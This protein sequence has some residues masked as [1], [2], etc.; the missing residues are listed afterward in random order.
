MT[1]EAVL[2]DVGGVFLLPVHERILG[3]FKRAECTVSADL[4]NAAH[5]RGAVRFT[6]ELDVD[7]D[8]A[9]SWQAY[10]VGYVEACGIA[11][12]VAEEVH[13]H[14]DSEFADAALWLRV[15]DGCR[16]GLQALADAGVRLGIISN[17]DGLIAERLRTLEI[18]QV[19]PGSRRGGRDDH[20]LGRGRR[21]EAGSTDLRDGARRDGH[22][23]RERLVRR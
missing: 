23:G 16:E 20:R 14:L 10:L 9:G 5:Y 12:D 15:V 22:R 13:R 17:A 2:L 6:T 7:G 18:L 1:P 4:L 19:G 11:T 21:D 3:A 8:W